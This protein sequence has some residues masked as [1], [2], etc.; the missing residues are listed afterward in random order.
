VDLLRFELMRRCSETLAKMPFARK[1]WNAD[2]Y[3]ALPDAADYRAVAPY[4][5]TTSMRWQEASW[6]AAKPLLEHYLVADGSNP[7]FS[8]LDWKRVSGAVRSAEPL[9]RS[10][11]RQ[12]YNALGAAI[13]LGGHEERVRIPAPS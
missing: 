7:L 8:I 1:K 4:T 6:E 2:V 9:A 13:W 12:L 5:G 10:Q 3:A 11:K